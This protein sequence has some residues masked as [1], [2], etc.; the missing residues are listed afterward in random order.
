MDSKKQGRF[1]YFYG[2][3]VEQ[4]AF[5][6][7]PKLLFEDPA[8]AA[9]SGDAKMLFGLM[10]DRA[11]LSADNNWIDEEGRVY[12]YYTINAIMDNL[13]CGNQKAVKLLKELED[14]ELIEKKRQGQGN[15]SV[16]YVKNLV[17]GIDFHNS[18]V[19]QNN[20]FHTDNC[21]ETTG[22]CNIECS[23]NNDFHT[24]QDHENKEKH[25]FRN[26]KNNIEEMLISQ[27]NKNNINN[28]EINNI[29]SIHSA[30]MKETS[31]LFNYNKYFNLLSME[32]MKANK[33]YDTA[34]LDLI[35]EIIVDVMTTS[36]PTIRVSQ[37]YMPTGLVR[38]RFK[39]LNA[40]HIE[41]VLECLYE[42]NTKPK[43]IYQYLLAMLYRAPITCDADYVTQAN[44]DIKNGL[45]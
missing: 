45:L 43:D 12:I 38:E 22:Y 44:V 34:V 27:S 23:M 19:A 25:T 35:L 11:S 26:V 33:Y 4:F 30:K 16:I 15:P 9:I 32:Q 14:A 40:S 7:V 10:L 17:T 2:K 42:I 31:R 24:T 5:I 20:D 13:K 39:K 29:E 21:V 41:Y 36:R 28:T 6:K 3:Q 18:I 37:E 8:L 1:D